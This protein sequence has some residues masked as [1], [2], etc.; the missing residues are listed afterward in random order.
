MKPDLFVRSA[1]NY[2]MDEASLETGLLC[3]DKTLAQQQ[4]KEESD[5]NTIVE[6]FHLTGE[7][8]QLQQV[9]TSAD[10][11]GVFD[12]QSAMNA[13]VAA[14]DTFMTMPAKIRTRFDNDP[15]KFHDFFLDP[16]NIPE[17]E[18]LGIIPKRKNDGNE[19]GSQETPNRNAQPQTPAARA[20]GSQ[21]GPPPA[22][23]PG[24]KATGS[25]R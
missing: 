7:V 9:P 19:S 23:G 13:I 15:Q 24:Q 20:P 22:Q 8:P 11:H 2:D 21:D 1:Y 10:Y 5:I 4:F 17:A 14:K 3:K 6:R 16:D 25:D 12:F 18:L